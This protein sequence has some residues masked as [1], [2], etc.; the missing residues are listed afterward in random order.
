MILFKKINLAC[1]GFFLIKIIIYAVYRNK[2]NN[3]IDKL[4]LNG[5]MYVPEEI[6]KFM[7]K[8]PFVSIPYHTD[9]SSCSM[10]LSSLVKEFIS[11]YMALICFT[12]IVLL[13]I[14]ALCNAIVTRKTWYL[15]WIVLFGV[16]PMCFE[17]ACLANI[18]SNKDVL[19]KKIKENKKCTNLTPDGDGEKNLLKLGDTLTMF[20]IIV[21][22]ITILASILLFVSMCLTKPSSIYYKRRR[23]TVNNK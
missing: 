17:I 21:I 1:W 14:I 13:I 8:Y 12:T 20:S 9:S 15:I 18:S 7:D 16:L 4:T 23:V 19:D 22:S 6:L 11:S 2:I 10:Y 5:Q 3:L